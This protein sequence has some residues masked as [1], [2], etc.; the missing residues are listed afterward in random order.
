MTNN[1]RILTATLLILYLVLPSRAQDGYLSDF[2]NDFNGASEKLVNLADVT[3]ADLYSWRPEGV[4]SISEVYVHVAN[5]NF[6]LAQAFGVPMPE[7]FA[8]DAEQT[9]TDKDEVIALLKLSQ[10]HVR[11]AVEAV[12]GEN[13]EEEVEAFG[14]T[15]SRNVVLLIIGGHSH[16]HLGQSIAYAR[17]NGIVPPWSQ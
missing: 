1:T 10:E 7:N 16:E 3:P 12:K 11:K 15:F 6:S 8:M 13:L 14:R 2:L 17:M 4:R 9:V 5:A